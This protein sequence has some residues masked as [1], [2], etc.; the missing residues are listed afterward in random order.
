V[1]R[2]HVKVDRIASAWLIGR[3]VDPEARFR[4]V[5]PVAYAH[6]PGELRFDMYEGEIG[7]EGDRC[8]FETLLARFGLDEPALARVGEVVHDIDCKE[9]RFGHPEVAGVAAMVAGVA[10][11][12]ERDEDRLAAGTPL[13]EALYRSFQARA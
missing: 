10:A 4:F 1:T 9:S 3:F 7:H 8:T 11:A 6:T 5:D 13:F 2:R 12:H